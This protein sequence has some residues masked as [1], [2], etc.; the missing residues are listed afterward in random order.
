MADTFGLGKRWV[1]KIFQNVR[2][3]MFAYHP[4]YIPK[5][6]ETLKEECK[7]SEIMMKDNIL[8]HKKQKIQNQETLHKGGH[9][10]TYSLI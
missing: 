5:L 6:V 7:G 2:R 3:S 9:D 1:N 8:T 10:D 4:T